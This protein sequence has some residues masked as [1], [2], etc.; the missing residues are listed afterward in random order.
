M[1]ESEKGEDAM[2]GHR[3]LPEGSVEFIEA[4]G[5]YFAQFDLPRIFGRIVGLLMVSEQ[6]MPHDEIARLLSISRGSVS[7]NIRLALTLSMA[8]RVAVPGD[9]RDF[10]RQTGD[11][12]GRGLEA[13]AGHLAP[14]ERMGQR[15]LE[16]LPDDHPTARAR[17][18]E[19]LDFCAFFKEESVGLFARWE[20]RRAARESLSAQPSYPLSSTAMNGDA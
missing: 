2:P 17:I 8:E 18:E 6:P 12:W 15:A 1:R 13:E 20:A 4:M 9:R 14:L 3:Q 11:T 10:Y 7:T 5:L 16:T 19:M